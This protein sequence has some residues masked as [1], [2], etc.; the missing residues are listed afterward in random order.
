[1]RSANSWG[2]LWALALILAFGGCAA[3][4]AQPDLP[5]SSPATLCN[6][7]ALDKKSFCFPSRAEA[8]LRT[9]KFDILQ[10]KKPKSGT[11]GAVILFL[12]YPDDHLVIKSKWKTSAKGGHAFNNEPRRELASY[13]AQALFLA[14]EEFV[15]PPTVGRCIPTAM[16][17]E[18]V[19]PAEETFDGAPCIFGVL[20]Y[21]LSNVTADHVFD[22]S[23]FDTDPAYRQSVANLN[24]LTYLIDHRDTRSSNFLVSTDPARPRTF[25]VD[26]GLAFSG[27]RNPIAYFIK[28]DWAEIIVPAL[29]RKQLERLRKLTR[30]DLETL[31]TVAQYSVTPHGLEE[32]PPTPPFSESRG[33]RRQGDV[34]QFG[35]TRREVDGIAA[36]LKALLERVDSGKIKV[37]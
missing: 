23:R 9:G 10:V 32:V 3:R 36:R 29:P 8:M 33:V 22:A 5:L 20:S 28:T 6:D 26:N 11:G 18:K 30:H 2:P 35:L 16:F 25:A 31:L 21:W 17:R 27:F 13:K 34:I 7:P 24:L 1:M 19:R 12:G 15:V 37:Y 14:P 4:L